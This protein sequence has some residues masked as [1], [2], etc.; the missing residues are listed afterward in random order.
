MCNAENKNMC[1]H[2]NACVLIDGHL[3]GFSGKTGRGTLRCL[4][5]ATG[6]MKWEEKSFGGIGALQAIGQKLLIIS[7]Q[8]ELV[9]AETNPD[10]F[11]E[12]SRAQVTGPKCWTT[13]VLSNGRVYCRNS[14]GDLICL[15]LSAK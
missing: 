13:P 4:E 12:I 1:N 7:N 3:Y 5:M 6:K 15:D 9:V 2:F 8:G 14:R 10:E 11:T